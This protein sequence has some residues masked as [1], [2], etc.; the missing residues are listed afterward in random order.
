MY[1]N[2][3]GLFIV[4]EG[5]D[6][7]GTT[8]QAK[9]LADYIKNELHF[10]DLVTTFEPT[11]GFYGR[12]IRE[13]LSGNREAY[14]ETLAE[15]FV[16]DSVETN[17]KEIIKPT[18]NRGGVV[19]SDRYRPSSFAYQSATGISPDYINELHERQKERLEIPDFTFYLDLN[20]DVAMKRTLSK[21][22]RIG[23][24]PEIFEHLEFQS[25]VREKYRKIIEDKLEYFGRVIIINADNPVEQVSSDI[26]KEFTRI[27]TNWS[28]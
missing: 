22:E 18:I 13:I 3:R 20:E 28:E 26:Q 7:S 15:L 1:S 10:E 24:P 23:A 19:L 2:E 6:G 11:K 21:L 17:N 4:F 27:Y 25:K 16:I 9:L 14:P 5:I 8:S 12:I